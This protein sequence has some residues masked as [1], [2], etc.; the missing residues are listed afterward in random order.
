MELCTRVRL[1]V[2]HHHC[3]CSDEIV[4]WYR[5]GIESARVA[6]DTRIA[7]LNADNLEELSERNTVNQ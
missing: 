6:G 3:L 4:L 2:M 7:W 1:I 5:R